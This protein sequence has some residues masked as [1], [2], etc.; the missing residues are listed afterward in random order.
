[1]KRIHIILAVLLT[2]ASGCSEQIIEKT[3]VVHL[4]VSGHV[5]DESGG[6]LLEGMQVTLFNGKGYNLL[7]PNPICPPVLTDETGSYQFE[8]T[9][10]PLIELYLYVVDI[11]G[12]E[13][14]GYYSEGCFLR[15]VDYSQS[16]L[17]AEGDFWDFGTIE[18][19]VDPIIVRASG[20][21]GRGPTR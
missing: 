12:P 8:Y 1:M 11:D 15:W 9:G 2:I 13:H 4:L 10:Q 17:Q 19:T 5:I 20:S 16:P 21:L 3:P 7:N 18:I 14:G 6:R